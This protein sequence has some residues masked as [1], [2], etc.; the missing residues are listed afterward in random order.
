MFGITNFRVI[1][2]TPTR[3]RALNLCEK[4]RSL[5]FAS[6]RF[7]FAD[8]DAISTDESRILAKIFFTPNDFDEGALYSFRD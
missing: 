1:T 5:G 2:V 3:Q 6:K 4:L 7:W 8:L